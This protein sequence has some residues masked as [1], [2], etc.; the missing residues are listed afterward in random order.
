MLVRVYDEIQMESESPKAFVGF[1]YDEN[2]AP[3]TVVW[4][5]LS[6]WK[7]FFTLLKA[8]WTTLTKG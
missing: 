3:G 4:T 5:S 6:K 2:D 8:A 1:Q 7:L